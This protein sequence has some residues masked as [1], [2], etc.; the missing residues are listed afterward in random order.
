[1]SDVLPSHSSQTKT[2]FERR[3]LSLQIGQTVTSQEPL[4]Q[5]AAVKISLLQE[6][7]GNESLVFVI[8]L[9]L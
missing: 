7:K 3:S 1:V 5:A 8:R 4:A 2:I 6:P 9:T